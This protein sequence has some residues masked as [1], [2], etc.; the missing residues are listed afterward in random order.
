MDQNNEKNQ[1]EKPKK[2]SAGKILYAVVILALTVVMIF[3]TAMYLRPQQSPQPQEQQTLPTPGKA[4][5]ATAP[6]TQPPTNPSTGDPTDPPAETPTD[7]PVALPTQPPVETPTDP[8]VLEGHTDIRLSPQ[9]GTVSLLGQAARDYLARDYV[10]DVSSF[11]SRYWETE[12]RSDRGQPVELAYTVYSLPQG[13]EVTDAV[14]RLYEPDGS[15]VYTEYRPAQGIR[16]V[17]IYNL[18]TGTDYSYSVDL[19]LSDGT[20][21]TLKGSFKTQ[22]GPRLM[23]ID[24]LVNVRDLGGW[25]TTDGR[26]VKQGLLYR[27]SEMDGMV[28]QDFKLTDKGLEQMKALG[29]KTDFD[30]R[31]QGADVLDGTHHYYDAI[32]YEYAFTPEGMEAVG[33]LFADLADPANYPAY[34][35]CT[36]GADRTGTMCYLLLG[37]LGVGDRDLKRDYE[38][39]ALYYGYVSGP[40]M[41]AFIDKIAALPGETTRQRVEYFL[42]SAGVTVEQMEAIRQ[43]F[44]G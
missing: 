8:P 7:P 36:Y 34:L 18:R 26:V 38:L 33:K 37:L 31:H 21:M 22:S 42:T 32:Q 1:A 13:V 15:G 12:Y 19:S 23:N 27:G 3:A 28:E 40:Q 35:H 25:T 6:S 14:F 29:I 4:P 43:I 20:R 17:S 9:G 10:S 24:G 11:L 2:V 39:T 44:L 5:T 41:D 16:R 30:L